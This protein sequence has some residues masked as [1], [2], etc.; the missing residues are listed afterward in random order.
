[1]KREAYFNS[2][3]KFCMNPD[4]MYGLGLQVHHI[5][6]LSQDGKDEEENYIILCRRCHQGREVHRNFERT[7]IL[8]ATYKYYAEAL[9]D[10]AIE[11]ELKI[12]DVRPL[13]LK[14]FKV[15]KVHSL[16]KKAT[17]KKRKRKSL[18][19]KKAKVTGRS[20]N[21]RLISP[22]NGNREIRDGFGIDG[23]I[24]PSRR[25]FE[26]A[27]DPKFEAWEGKIGHG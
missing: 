27:P 25:K 11:R 15:K 14:R 5:V 17:K 7:E 20:K 6:P 22:Q 3:G 23:L 12:D 21:Y 16:R 18:K 13:F 19:R 9:I 10:M 26:H 8:L 2:Y 1:M 24:Y 4:C